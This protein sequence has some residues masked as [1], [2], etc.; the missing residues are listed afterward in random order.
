MKKVLCA[1]CTVLL[2]ASVGYAADNLGP[3]NMTLDYGSGAVVQGCRG[4][5]IP[6]NGT[7]AS[8]PFAYRN[9]VVL[10][11]GGYDDPATG[12][13]LLW[14]KN[15]SDQSYGQYSSDAVNPTGATFD[16]P[17]QS[18]DANWH[19]YLCF[20]CHDGTLASQN[21]PVNTMGDPLTLIINGAD[22]MQNDHPVGVILPTDVPA[23]YEAKANVIA[24]SGGD[25]ALYCDQGL[26]L[27]GVGKDKVECATCHNPH[28]QPTVAVGQ[29]GNFLR[30]N[31]V[32]N[33]KLCRTC[34][35]DKR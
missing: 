16:L 35:L 10:G 21:L 8:S 3:H 23:R 22:Q 2:L 15:I 18:N 17:A 27:F 12:K 29:T 28:K 1:I 6:H 25:V 13:W 4:C 26:P 33:T 19:S 7:S 31:V 32:D 9:T 34:H 5:H 30:M 24:C 11:S 20:S 14:D